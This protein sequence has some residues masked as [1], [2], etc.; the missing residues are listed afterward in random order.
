MINLWTRVLVFAGL[1]LASTAAALLVARQAFFQTIELKASDASFVLRGPI[2]TGNVILVTADRKALETF[3]ELLLFWHPYYA[4]T[5]RAAAAAG[6][7]LIGL[8]VAF[9]AP[10]EKWEPGLDGMLVEAVTTAGIPVVCG[11]VPALAAKQQEWPVPINMTAAAL[12]LSGYANL[13]VDRDDFV[14]NQEL[15]AAP[16]GDEPPARS[17]AL[18]LAEK[19]IGRDARFEN[20]ALV[21]AGQRIPAPD[22]RTMRINYAGPPETFPRVSIAEVAAAIRDSR[23]DQLRRWFQGNIVLIGSDHVEDR[24]AT[25]YYGLH[26]GGSWNSAGVEIHASTLTT[27]LERRYLLPARP[28]T[29]IA[30][31]AAAAGLTAAAIAA[32]APWGIAGCLIAIWIASVA[33][34]QLV[35]RSGWV[36]PWAEMILASLLCVLAALIYR[37]AS[38]ESRGD[39]FRSAI[40]VFVGKDVA[41]S[42]DRSRRLGLTGTREEVT[43]LF[44]DLRGFTAFCETQDPAEIVRLLN[45]YFALVV[46]IVISQGGQ[47]NK[48]IGDGMLAVFTADGGGA[49]GSHAARAVECARQIVTYEHPVFQTGA[50]LHSGPVVIGNVGSADKM[51]YTVLGDTV[52]LAS[53]LESMNKQQGTS[54]LMSESTRVLL[55]DDVAAVRLGEVAVRGLTVPVGV[56][57]LEGLRRQ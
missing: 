18:R 36:L 13:T 34:S 1:A 53:R 40:A 8:D 37:F 29:R 5:I 15:I 11:Y 32:F 23:S 52:N 24:H 28:W 19:Y 46:K 31:L 43:I 54:L 3:P 20:G 56:Y 41:A 50:G 7:K 14:R 39:L 47:V 33:V 30:A 16:G 21:L 12:G 9:A 4:Q 35:F 10:V 55:P 17:F 27:L 6:A 38:A 51:E 48:F 49:P 26:Q 2:S 42:L 44:T 22:G 45:E 25:P 57:T